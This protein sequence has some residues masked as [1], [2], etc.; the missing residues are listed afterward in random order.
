[1]TDIGINNFLFLNRGGQWPGFRTSG[2]EL[3]HDGVLHLASLPLLAGTIP[4]AVKLASIPDGPTGLAIDPM[5]TLYFSDP[6]ENQVR[7]MLG[8][9][10]SVCRVPCLGGPSGP[11][12][13]AGPRGLLIP[14]TRPAL[15]VV[16]SGNHRIKILDLQTFELT[17]IW[18]QPNPYATGP[19]SGPGEFD[20]PWTLAADSDGNV[21]VVDYGNQR[22]Q[23]FNALGE[24]V[25]QFCSNVQASGFLQQPAD[26]AVLETNGEVRIFVVDSST[27]EIVV[28]DADG[29]PARDSQGHAHVIHDPHL[30]EPM[31]IAVGGDSLYVGDNRSERVLRFQ[32]G[33]SIEFAGEAI[34]YQG[35]V[36]ALLLDRAGNLWVHFGGA[37]TPVQLTARG[38][39]RTIGTLW[40]NLKEPVTV[41][42][43][44]RWHRLQA[45]ARALPANAHLDLYAFASNDLA[46]HPTVDPN[47]VDPF[48]DPKWLSIDY[49]ANLDVTDLFIGPATASPQDEVLD[50]R[51]KYLWLGAL[52][53]SDGTSSPWVSQL[54]VE[55]DYPSYAQYLPAI[56]RNTAGCRE[57]LTRLLSLFESF[58]SRVEGEI[59]SL[60]ALFDPAAAPRRFLGWLA[61]CMGL[62]LDDNWDDETQRRIIAHIF[63]LSGKRGTPEG[64]REFLRLLAGV[65]AT[66][67][68]PLLHAAW[69]ALPSSGACC[70]ACAETSGLAG[71]TWQGAENS[72]LGWTT[73][74]APAQPQ[75]AVVGASAVLDQSHLISDEEFGAPL[76]SDVAYQFSVE[77][78]RSQVMCPETLANVRAIIEREKPAHTAYHLCIIDPRFRVGFQSRLG[79]DTVV[80]GQPRSL[81]LGTEQ[82]LG[83]DS[84]LAGSPPSL[85]GTETSLGVTTRLG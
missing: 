6:D 38:G 13:L 68:E 71:A 17:E 70:H 57:F 72:L 39:Y 26:I 11:I 54:R 36:A 29:T 64:L 75:G 14:S 69:W 56:Y 4:D 48:S 37:I 49:T 52:F 45:I 73:M 12:G 60:P 20:T 63:E 31:G 77:L 30:T 41:D 74:L 66:V 33:D 27:A 15:F 18:G 82:S 51:A 83:L 67:E 79:I 9:D 55:F 84:V 44:V 8:C 3:R 78:Y 65:D 25:P 76:F 46:R 1:M 80:A 62:N 42:R 81:S 58:F 32:I 19:G 59:E 53:T 85:L 23:K 61:G 22:V 40:I 35:P 34:G 2:L 21:Y 5:G 50:G 10:A 28:F 7:R 16:D 47:S 43:P 24:A